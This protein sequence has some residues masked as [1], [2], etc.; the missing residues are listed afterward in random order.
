MN[1]KRLIFRLIL[2]EKS[3][4]TTKQRVG[5]KSDPAVVAFDV[6]IIITIL[7]IELQSFPRL[8]NSKSDVFSDILFV[9][10]LFHLY[11]KISTN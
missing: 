6:F 5:S 2:K 8:R 7:S 9:I 3:Q 10:T 11:K 1:I 4:C